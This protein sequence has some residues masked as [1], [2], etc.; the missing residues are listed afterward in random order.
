MY[1]T[2]GFCHI[3]STEVFNPNNNSFSAFFIGLVFRFVLHNRPDSKGA[4]IV[5]YLFVVLSPCAFIAAEYVLLGRLAL[6]LNAAEHLVIS[7]RRVTPLFV[8]SD[9][10]TFLIQAVGG[11][12]SISSN[13]LKT[14]KLGSNVFLVGLALQLASFAIF[15]C[16]YLRFLFLVRR[17]RPEVWTRD[18]SFR[19]WYADWRTLACAFIVSCAGILVRS[20]FRVIELSQGFKGPLATSETD[21][22]GLDTLPL[23][24]AVAAYV[25]FWPGRFIGRQDTATV[26]D[27]PHKED[28]EKASS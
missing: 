17:H 1:L 21:F 13:D 18:G 7:P 28:T 16:M 14:N 23:F 27:A 22:Y 15:T 11:S 19:L 10:T 12:I 25:P 4:Y 6:D 26:A 3:F 5:E 2:V 8:A 20:V 9:I 24:I